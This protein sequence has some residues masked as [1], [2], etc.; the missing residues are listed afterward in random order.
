MK[1][2]QSR[3]QGYYAK[4]SWG[5]PKGKKNETEDTARCAGRE[6]FEETAY[7]PKV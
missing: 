4:N 1:V 2:D 3:T 7:L 6:V 5:F